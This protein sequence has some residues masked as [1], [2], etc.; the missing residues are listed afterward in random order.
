MEHFMKIIFIA[1]MIFCFS[2][3]VNAQSTEATDKMCAKIKVCALEQLGPD[4]P[5]EVAQMMESMF[6]GICDNML[7]SYYNSAADAGIEGKAQACAESFE[8]LSCDVI[9]SGDENI[10]PECDELKK[11]AEEAGIETN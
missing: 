3:F 2:G 7:Q 1:L 6:D 9:M 5:P 11:A 10:S 8:A 4:S